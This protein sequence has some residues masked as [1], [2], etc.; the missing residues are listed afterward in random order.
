MVVLLSKYIFPKHTTG[1]NGV[2]FLLSLLSWV[3]WRMWD[4]LFMRASPHTH[5]MFSLMSTR[6]DTSFQ[7]GD[8][9]RAVHSDHTFFSYALNFAPACSLARKIL[10]WVHGKKVGRSGLSLSHLWF[11][12]DLFI[13][14]QAT[15][16]KRSH[17]GQRD[18]RLL[19]CPFQT[20]SLSD[21]QQI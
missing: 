14:G 1:Y 2:L 13:F 20:R 11:A 7:G 5:F 19:L 3:F 16:N 10:G 12:D 8:F 18:A 4:I 15:T 21:L 17:G 6:K 9:V